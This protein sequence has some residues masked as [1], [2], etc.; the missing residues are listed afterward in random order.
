MSSHRAVVS[1][2]ER[3]VRNVITPNDC[4]L[5]TQSKDTPLK[6]CWLKQL[7][8]ATN[9]QEKISPDNHIYL[10]LWIIKGYIF[11]PQEYSSLVSAYLAAQLVFGFHWQSLLVSVH[12]QA[13]NHPHVKRCQP[14]GHLVANMA[15]TYTMSHPEGWDAILREPFYRPGRDRFYPDSSQ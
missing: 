7:P 5:Y 10:Y 8:S 14:F 4:A 9:H 13:G 2:I 15:D 6:K 12:R 3:K 11:C 1:S